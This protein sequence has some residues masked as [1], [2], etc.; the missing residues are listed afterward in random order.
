MF[1]FNVINIKVALSPSEKFDFVCFCESPLKMMK[2]AIC[3]IS[4]ALFVL[5]VFTFLF[6]IFGY[7]EKRLDKK[8]IVNFKIYDFTDWTTNNC[9]TSV[10]TQYLKKYFSIFIEK[11]C[12]K[13][14]REA[15]ARLFYIKK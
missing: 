5:E 1:K 2:N 10:I 15:R 9:N 4:E 6:R 11:S 7:L 3:F 8:D 14:G 13:Y 12:T